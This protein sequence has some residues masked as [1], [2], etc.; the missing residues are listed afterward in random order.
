MA[1]KNVAD[2]AV[3][4]RADAVHTEVVTAILVLKEAVENQSGLTDELRSLCREHLAPYEVPAKFEYVERLPRS[5]LG[6]LLR[7]D[8]RDAAPAEL[9]QS[10]R[11]HSNG[12]GKHDGNGN[13][14]RVA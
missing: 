13:G 5:P 12:N 6:K 11:E 3:V 10:A 1:H 7:K 4:G 2:V 8:L 14:K 9:V